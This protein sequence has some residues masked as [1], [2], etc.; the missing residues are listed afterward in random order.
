MTDENLYAYITVLTN[1]SYIPGVQALAESLRRVNSKYRLIILVPTERRDALT[2]N[3]IMAT[4][5]CIL[6]HA[7]M[8]DT[9]LLP[10]PPPSGTLLARDI[11]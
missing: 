6:R 1:E 8:I 4:N 10:P 7:P 2:Y 5:N 11:L 9:I 3:T